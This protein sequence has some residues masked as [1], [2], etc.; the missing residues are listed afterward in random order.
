MPSAISLLIS[1]ELVFNFS[2]SAK[3][4]SSDFPG[5][6][7][8]VASKTIPSPLLQVEIEQPFG[9]GMPSLYDWLQGAKSS[10]P[11][12]GLHAVRRMA[13]SVALPIPTLLIINERIILNT[14]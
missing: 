1:G 3:T 13:K 6:Q 9:R 7:V 10:S 8:N 2:T 11:T 14:N 4:S 5:S 12:C